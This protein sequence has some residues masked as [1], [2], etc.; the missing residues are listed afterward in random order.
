V[1]AKQARELLGALAAC[2]PAG[3]TAGVREGLALV[4]RDGASDLW[5]IAVRGGDAPAVKLARR[6]A[7]GATKPGARFSPAAFAEPVASAL[8]TFDALCPIA[9]VRRGK[10]GAW[11]LVLSRP[12]AWPLFLRCDLSAAFTP[13]AAQWSLVLRDARVAALD[14]DGEA[15]WAR[16]VG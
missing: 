12:V 11:T 13:G 5:E 10:A 6:A 2:D 15:L 3:A 8:K 14:F 16:C 7:S 9:E 4:A 1:N